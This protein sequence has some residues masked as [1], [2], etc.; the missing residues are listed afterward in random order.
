MSSSVFLCRQCA[1]N[2]W[3]LAAWP[4]NT[5]FFST[6][7]GIFQEQYCLSLISDD[8]LCVVLSIIFSGWSQHHDIFVAFLCTSGDSRA[9][10]TN[11]LICWLW[12]PN[13]LCTTNFLDPL[14]N[15]FL[16]ALRS[17]AALLQMVIFWWPGMFTFKTLFQGCQF[18]S[19]SSLASR[20]QFTPGSFPNFITSRGR[21]RIVLP[22]LR[23]ESSCF[24]NILLSVYKGIKYKTYL[25]KKRFID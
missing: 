22:M 2:K 7:R 11:I 8:F 3:W 6:R 4:R 23:S 21:A 10:I 24:L 25:R 16:D 1:C 15:N 20:R 14:G 17:L 18:G 12:L 5:Y 13:R 19:S 9:G